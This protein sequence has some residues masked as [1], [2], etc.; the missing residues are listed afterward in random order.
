VIRCSCCDAELTIGRK[1][2]L[3]P[4]R[5]P[6]DPAGG[7]DAPAYQFYLTEL[8]CRRAL[9]CLPCYRT[10]DNATGLAEIGGRAFHL[11]G[12]SRGDKAPVLNEG[13]Y[14]KG[15]PPACP[16]GINRINPPA[17]LLFRQHYFE[18]RL[19]IPTTRRWKL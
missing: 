10:L 11:A 1:V 5:D 4:W 13:K 7:P 12:A 16:G 3:R 2:Q 6:P 9:L 14:Q 17:H 18:P 19:A 15:S 8:T